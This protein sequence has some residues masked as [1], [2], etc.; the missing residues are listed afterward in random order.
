LPEQ[1]TLIHDRFEIE[2]LIARGGMAIVYKGTDL[3]LG[4]TVAIKIL[5]EELAQ[6]PSFVARFRLEAQ[7][8]ASLTHP[9]I[10]AVY[11]T[12]SDGDIHYIVMEYLEG[13]TLHQILN[14]QG[15]VPPEEVAS[16]GAEVAQ[17]LAEAHEKG[18]VHRD[19]KPG[20]IM[21]SRNG[22]AKVMDFGIAKAATAGNLTQVGSI[23][24]TVAYLS[25][26][27][28]RG[29]KVDGRSDIY[30]LG[31]LLYQ[32]LT[33]NLPLKGDT[34]VEMVHKLNSQDPTNPSLTNP[35]IPAALDSVVMRALAKDPEN[36]YQTGTEMAADL[37]ASMR[38]PVQGTAAYAPFPV[39]TD[40]TMVA[41]AARVVR[42]ESTR[43]MPAAAAAAPVRVRQAPPGPS[44]T[45]K[46][47][48][49][50]AAIV[51]LLAIALVMFNSI[52]NTGTNDPTPTPSV[53]TSSVA[54]PAPAP[55]P[56]PRPAPPAEPPPPPA[57][58]P[59][60]EPP[61]PAPVD[62]PPA[63]VDPPPAPVDPPPA[64]APA[65]LPILNP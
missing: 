48:I 58:P 20:N 39:E 54:P 21:I 19:V 35:A 64:P 50:I 14:E 9:N 29:E 37:L 23:L 5:S 2:S 12:G 61:P 52:D 22:N 7:A 46:T 18:I 27:Q 3:T 15:T 45:T 60:A 16:I 13:R 36:R 4:R 41:P 47:L 49:G 56:A 17:A 62:P 1:P 59:P 30:S 28:A 42:D 34:Y 63:P 25:P 26:E 43:V 8:A 40:K 33:G 38:E 24:G 31:A 10:V 44:N 6:D 53:S 32:M 51:A 65:P 57:E 11:D 55:R